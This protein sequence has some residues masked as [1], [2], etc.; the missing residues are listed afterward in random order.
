MGFFF[1]TLKFSK[2]ILIYIPYSQE[3]HG[4]I[5]TFIVIGSTTFFLYIIVSIKS[6]HV[7]SRK[8]QN[9]F[10]SDLQFYPDK[11]PRPGSA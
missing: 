1:L 2:C 8:V 10:N 3:D 11:E 9:V 7:I 4:K 6:I 5:H